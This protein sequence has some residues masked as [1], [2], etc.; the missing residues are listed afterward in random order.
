M[1]VSYYDGYV[2]KITDII[3]DTIVGRYFT[4]KAD[5]FVVPLKSSLLNIFIVDN[6]SDSTKQWNK[7]FV[8]KKLIIFNF[9]N[10]LIAMPII[11][12]L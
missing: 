6:L 12:N 11:H 8:N 2:V 9:E 4:N 1:L 7:D 10:K 5:L 3:G